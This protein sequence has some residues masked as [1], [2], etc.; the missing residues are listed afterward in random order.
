MLS[1]LSVGVPAARCCPAAESR[2]SGASDPPLRDDRRLSVLAG[3]AG[4]RQFL[5]IGVGLPVGASTHQVAQQLAPE[6]RVV[7]VDSDPLVLV[8]ARALLASAPGGMASYIEADVRDTGE[9]LEQ[10]ARTLDFGQPVALMMLGIL[11][12]IPD[13][14][15]PGAI[16]AR[17]LGPLPP[18]SY[19]ALSDGTGTSPVLNQ[20]IAACNQISANP[21]HLR[22]PGQIARFFDGLALVPPGVVTTPRWRPDLAAASARLVN[23]ICGVGRKR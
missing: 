8:R 1:A 14:A 6:P 15:G 3:E 9:I 7:Y 5:D 21:Y 4:I 19:L 13:A 16:V 12:Q 18:G 23:A 10:A 20:A 11:G 22:S 2:R 17:L